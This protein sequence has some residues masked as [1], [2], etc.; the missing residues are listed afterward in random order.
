MARFAALALCLCA[1][2]AVAAA[3]PA[4]APRCSAGSPVAG[5]WQVPEA[6]PNSA[7][8]AVVIALV[9]GGASNSTW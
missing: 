3:K 7:F 1:V 2:L 4:P 8:A 6:V 9:E 5:G